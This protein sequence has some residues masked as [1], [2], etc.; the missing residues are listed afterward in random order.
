MFVALNG[1]ENVVWPAGMSGFEID[2]VL[3]ES[4]SHD[5]PFSTENI[6]LHCVPVINLFPW[7]PIHCIFLRWKMNTCCAPC[8]FRTG[9]RNLLRR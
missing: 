4:W 2:V 8:V 5:L 3:A 9:I 6:R 7:K 1:L